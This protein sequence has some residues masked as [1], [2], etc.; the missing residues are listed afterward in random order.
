MTNPSQRIKKGETLKIY[1]SPFQGQQFEL[2]K[3]QVVFENEDLLV[4]GKPANLN[5]HSVPSSMQY[6]LTFGVIQYL[7]LNGVSF[8]PTPPMR[9]DRPVQGLVVFGKNSSAEKR[10][11]QLVKGK[12][13]GKW[14]VGV[15]ENTGHPPYLRVQ[16]KILNNGARST[17][18]ELGKDAHSLFCKRES[19]QG[20]EIFSIFIFTGRRHQIRAHAAHYLAPIVG[21][22][23][24]GSK[25]KLK[26]DEIALQ[27][28]GYNIPWE[29][30]ILRLRQDPQAYDNLKQR[31]LQASQD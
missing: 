8:E 27:C 30:K 13:I 6:N 28:N 1:V 19:L 11:F 17:P 15:L 25:I 26:S 10:L 9:L 14:Y 5:I 24:Y 7:K 18:H 29:G 16:D 12:K 21:D 22:R 2:R 3:S 20:I 31:A 23:Q 4:V